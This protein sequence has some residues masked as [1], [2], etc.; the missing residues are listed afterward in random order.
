MTAVAV[1]LGWAIAGEPLGARSL[2]AAALI[3]G[4]VAA[5]LLVKKMPVKT[6]AEPPEST[7]LAA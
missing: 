5:V 3:V 6:A 7:R 4:A 1:L 2:F